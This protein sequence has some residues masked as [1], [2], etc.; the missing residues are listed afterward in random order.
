[1]ENF[2]EQIR[3][4]QARTQSTRLQ[5]LLAELAS[6]FIAVD[7][8]ATELSAGSRD[9][10]EREVAHAEKGYAVVQDL[11]PDLADKELRDGFEP[12]LRE[13]RQEID[14]LKGKLSSSSQG[15]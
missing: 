2:A 5:F 9:I 1:M 13:L 7:F 12:R 8:G 11:L 15:A 4:L 10:A 3:E 6:C 14:L